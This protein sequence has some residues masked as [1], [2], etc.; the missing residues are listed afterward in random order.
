MRL[1]RVLAAAS[2][3]AALLTQPLA[4]Q[5]GR[6]FKD[7]WFWGLKGGGLIYSSASTERSVAPLVGADWFITRSQGGLYVS[8]DESFFKTQGSFTD[9]DPSNVSFNHMVDLENLRR[10]NVAGMVFPMQSSTV[11]PYVGL[12]VTFTQIASAA[13]V[14]GTASTSRPAAALDSVQTKRS[15]FSPL[16]IGGVQ[17]RLPRFSVFGQVTAAHQTDY[18]LHRGGHSTLFSLE[19]GIRYNVGSSIDRPR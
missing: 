4:A 5:E 11:H 3:F 9:R 14:G 12:G 19:G 13:M 17:V 15:T 16:A 10:V 18:F 8:F 6:Q 7:A 1:L 2:A